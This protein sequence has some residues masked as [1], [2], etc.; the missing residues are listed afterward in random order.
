MSR[1]AFAT[2]FIYEDGAIDD[3]A[4]AKAALAAGEGVKVAAGFRFE[5]LQS[6][7]EK[8][9]AV[10]RYAFDMASRI[11]CGHATDVRTIIAAAEEIEAYLC[12]R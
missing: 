3:A 1:D 10:R 6:R 12:K 2:P 5:V 4:G 8:I 9:F 7:S 11:L